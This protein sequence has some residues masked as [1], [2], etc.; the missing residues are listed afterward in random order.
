MSEKTHFGYKQVDVDKKA[1]M[2]KEVFDS[3]ASEYDIMNDL[4]SFG[5]HRLWK[6]YT[7]HIANIHKNARI[8]DVASGSGDLGLLFHRYIGTNGELYLT[9]INNAMLS[10]A[11]DRLTDA[12]VCRNVHYTIADAENLPFQDN[13]F[14]VLS[15]AF[16]L[17][18]VTHKE[19]ALKSMYRV[20]KP[21]GKLMILEFSTPTF[22]GL[23][24]IYDA[25]SFQ[26]LPLMGKVIA[27]DA[28]S[29]RYLA[30]SIRMHPDQETLKA[31]IEAQG[32]EDCRYDNLT[33]GIV[34]LHTAYKY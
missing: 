14:D 2:V 29:Y 21:G 23:K 20:L 17:R 11:R 19:N 16:G 7:A 33:G 26:L 10:R 31:M 25:Y 1:S 32:F 4:M 22:P 12:G 6:Q 18:N 34:A 15:I 9:D 3:V 24:P 30:E 27:N 13:Y 8:L 5:I 28:E